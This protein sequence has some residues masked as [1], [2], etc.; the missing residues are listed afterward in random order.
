[1]GY[2]QILLLPFLLAATGGEK[3]GR[4]KA[5]ETPETPARGEPP[6]STLLLKLDEKIRDDS[7]LWGRG[8]LA[9]RQGQ[10]PCTPSSEWISG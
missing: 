4:G 9:L 10:S 3:R 1:M 7:C 2:P 6:L 5:G 8:I